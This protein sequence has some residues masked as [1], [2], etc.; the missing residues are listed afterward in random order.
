MVCKHCPDRLLEFFEPASSMKMESP[1]HLVLHPFGIQACASLLVFLC[2]HWH[3]KEELG[4]VAYL[5]PFVGPT[6]Y[7]WV[8]NQNEP[9]VWSP[10]LLFPLLAGPFPK[11]H[12]PSIN[13]F[14]K[15]VTHHYTTAWIII[16][17]KF[18]YNN[19]AGF[20]EVIHY[21]CGTSSFHTFWQ[22]FI[23]FWTDDLVM[24]HSVWALYISLQHGFQ[25]H[26]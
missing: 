4:I 11:C 12:L 16:A 23:M 24:L 18:P 14:L 17:N 22:S 3:C 25:S 2:F 1:I 10:G 5:I 21:S 13:K 26:G 8:V 6:V 19:L 20:K 15:W 7:W 9:I